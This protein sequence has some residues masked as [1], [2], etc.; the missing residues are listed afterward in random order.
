VRKVDENEEK[1][2]RSVALQN[3]QAVLLAR[4]KA[5]RE[6]RESNERVTNILESITDAFIVLDKEWRF[7]YM[8]QQA[9]QIVRP[10]NKSRA[11]V[12]GKN[13]WQEFPD[14][15]GTELETNFRRAMAEKVRVQ[16][17][18]LYRPLNGWF[19]FRAYPGREG[20]SIYFLDITEQRRAA[21]ALRESEE[22]FRAIVQA[23]PECVKVVAAD[24]TL[25]A[26]NSAGC[27]MVEAASDT[28]VVGKDVYGLIAPEFRQRF[29]EFNQSVCHGNKGHIEFQIVG[30][31][32]TWRWMETH[33]VPM[34]EPSTGQTVQLA[35]TRDVTARKEAEDKL[36]R[37]EEDL[38]ALAN[39]I[40]QLAWMANP[41]G[42]I[43]WYNHGWYDYTG[44]T[45]E[46]MQGWGWQAVHD[47]KVLPTVL[48]R[49]QDSIRNGTPF[50]ME[51]PLKGADGVYQWFLT[52]VS[53]VRDD[54]GRITR[55][56]GTNTNI[57]EQ[58]QLLQSLSEAR[59]HLEQRVQ[60]RTAELK[61]ANEN[62]VEL[63]GRLQQLRDEERRRIARELHD[64]VG[65]MLAALS[66]NIAVVQSQAQDL[67]PIVARAVHDNASIVE[68][69][70]DEIRT[71][72]HLLH[73]PLLDVAGLASAVRWYV[74]GFSD[75]SKIKVELDIPEGLPRLFDEMEITIFRLVQECLTNIHRH[76]GSDT[77]K[78]A[79]R[80]EQHNLVVEIKDAGKG[81]PLHKQLELSSGRMGVG[82]RGMRER[83]KQFGGDFDIQS[84]S[85]GTV[86]TATMPLPNT[87][88]TDKQ[89]TSVL[90]RTS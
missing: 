19:H 16:F 32:G 66:M 1:L 60:E 51:F 47:P 87:P 89:G 46:Q 12:L 88:R 36:R 41:G 3:A 43:F 42:D 35:I 71:I 24:G 38:R 82:F 85:S 90:G 61:T 55:W 23:T 15:V 2:L 76:S 54:Q 33:A 31:K 10:L 37:S 52:R 30:L 56:F 62:L 72:S 13:Y 5:E 81:I 18:F 53:P 28:E 40:P 77:A 73:P 20:L 27:S 48:E 25:L 26:M 58:R 65:Q 34:R 14:L 29:V 45:F 79:I 59:D 50:E 17:E 83:L 8:N 44:T 69:I 84:D 39:S 49:W 75:R 70:G 7:T 11:T 22:R 57:N 78:I 67:D 63:S 4:E 9:E 74:D 86:V 68:Q 21:E 6:L 64:S 80:I